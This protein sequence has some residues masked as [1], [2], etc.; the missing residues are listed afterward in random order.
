MT[1]NLLIEAPQLLVEALQRLHEAFIVTDAELDEPGPRILFANPAF[2]EMTGYSWPE[3]VGQNPRFLQG[4]ETDRRVLRNLRA[5]LEL[6]ETFEGEAVNYRKD[7]APFIMRWYIEPIRNAGGDI[8]HFFGIQRDVT[9]ERERSRQQ[10]ALEQAIGQ[11]ADNVVLFDRSGLV[12]Y[13]N[14]A[15]FEW[16]SA[17]QKAVI[18]QLAWKLPGA[19]EQVTELHWARKML[20]RGQGWRRAYAVRRGVA[21]RRFVS[22]TVSPIR[23]RV[24]DVVEFLA[25]GRD[26]TERR[27]LESIA[28]AHNFH[29]HLGV[30]FSGIRHELGNPINSVKAALQ[31]VNDGLAAMPLA[32]ARTYLTRMGDELGR[33]ESLLRSLRSYSLYD[34]PK[35][36]LIDVQAFLSRFQHLAQ[37]ECE[38][39]GVQLRM[40]ISDRADTLWGDPQALHQVLLN[41]IGNA[42]V[43][44]VGNADHQIEI[45]ADRQSE[46]IELMVRDNGPGIPADH[47]PHVFKPFYTTRSGGTGLGLAI[48]RHLLSLMRGSI[49]LDSSTAGT[50]AR[51]LFDRQDPKRFIGREAPSS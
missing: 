25:V 27:R 47:L 15:Y 9:A 11:L 35:P 46:H 33:V 40:H 19:P 13:A 28:E 1:P 39:Q 26:V 4:P 44:F 12:R 36:E 51:L 2:L 20:R 30:V 7:G 17:S 41:L 21:E 50:E 45:L 10:R 37:S 43:A 3:L 42:M 8:T 14:E 18:G 49:E 38:R 34:E 6:G 31:V 29:D 48:S 23:D 32:K 24:G 22:V 5:C 16:S